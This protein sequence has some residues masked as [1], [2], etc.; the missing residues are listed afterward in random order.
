MFLRLKLPGLRSVEQAFTWGSV[1]WVING[2]AVFLPFCNSH[3]GKASN[4]SGWTAF[5]GA[6]IFEFGSVLA[7]WEAWNADTRA[8]EFN[9][10]RAVAR[11]KED[12]ENGMKLVEETIGGRTRSSSAP[13]SVDARTTENSPMMDQKEFKERPH[14]VWFSTERKYWHELGWYAAFFQILA[15]SV[16]WISG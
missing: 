1:V 10:E 16:F 12:V 15:A 8:F 5:I 2:F 3:F 6:T 9:V 13:A 4:S 14:W 7:V 11:V